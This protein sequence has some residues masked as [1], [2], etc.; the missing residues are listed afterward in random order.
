MRHFNYFCGA[1]I[2][3]SALFALLCVSGVGSAQ[4]AKP[5]NNQAVVIEYKEVPLK[6]V[7]KN[8]TTQL[9]LNVVF[10]ETFRDE[11]KYDLELTDVTLE[12]A[13]KI[14]LIQKRMM[15]RVI[16]DRTIIIFHDNPTNR[17]RFEEYPAW[18]AK[19]EQKR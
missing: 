2:A 14:V 13:L 18:P 17:A 8:L 19:Y 12:A 11:P 9:K 7:I 15:A 5:K 16:E 6:A 1:G 3:L 4:T 10:D